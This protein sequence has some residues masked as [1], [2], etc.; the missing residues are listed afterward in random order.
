MT[1]NTRSSSEN[2]DVGNALEPLPATVPAARSSAVTLQG[3]GV[4]LSAS[5]R[6]LPIVV[7]HEEGPSLLW[8]FPLLSTVFVSCT[9]SCSTPVAPLSFP[10]A[11]L[12]KDR[13]ESG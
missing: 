2:P 3:P 4:V 12:P 1:E 11:A 9:P 13:P 5:P 8:V 10:L 6:S 7:H